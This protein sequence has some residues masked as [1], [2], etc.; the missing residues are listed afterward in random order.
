MPGLQLNQIPGGKAA[1][2]AGP[3]NLSA[4]CER[5]DGKGWITEPNRGC[6]APTLPPGRLR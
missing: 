6:L 5:C 2:A 1:R 3:K 4:R